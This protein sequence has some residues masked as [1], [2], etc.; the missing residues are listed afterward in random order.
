MTE[1]NDHISF[2]DGR[3]SELDRALGELMLDAQKVLD[4]QGRLRSLLHA[5]RSV[6][7]QLDLPVVLRR[8]VEAAVELV[9]ARYG[10]LGVVAPDGHLEQ[11]VHV[12]IP[13][14]LAAR[15]GQLP[16]GL[17]LLGALVEDPRPIRLEH[18]GADPRSVGFP[19]HHPPMDSFVGVPVRVRDEVFGNLYLSEAAAG[20][21]T[22]EDEELLTALAAT[23]GVA[24][25]NA[26]LFGE[27]RRRQHWSSALAEITTALLSDLD[28]DPLDMLAEHVVSLAD[29]DL[30]TVLRPVGG[31]LLMVDVAKG[32][33]AGEL[34]GL[35]FRSAGT[36]TGRAM[37][38]GQPVLVSE[39]SGAAERPLALGPTM[40]IPMVTSGEPSG[41]LSVAR[42]LGRPT[43]TAQDLEMA[44][45]F[46]RQ[47]NVAV[48][49]AAARADQQRFVILEDRSRIAG[50]LHDHVIQR[51]FAAGLGLQAVAGRITDAAARAKITEQVQSLDEAITAIRT[52]IFALTTQPSRKTPPLRH[53]VIDL[54]AE[55]SSIFP[56][57]PRLAFS[58]PVDLAIPDAV[59]DDLLAVLREGLTNVARHADAEEAF[60][61]ITVTDDEAL[62]EIV[63]NG[64]GIG[65][66]RRRSGIASMQTRAARWDGS[67]SYH[68]KPG[69]GTVLDWTARLRDAEDHGAKV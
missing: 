47:A 51:L 16:R 39:S 46:A 44:T 23:A 40:V 41:A 28:A 56:L 64:V 45:D 14:E 6:V 17:G 33:L 49:L 15:M 66:P 65:R 48:Q 24:I 32:K 19:P 68:A 67:V 35:V 22:E 31:D 12:G 2:P 38:S 42:M 9:G 25:D 57:S 36:L 11:F 69:G 34:N 21:F 43:F 55:L 50:D 30:V 1:R 54:V 5:S 37:A 20:A 7:E 8:I 52:A 58:G 62:L 27:T 59:A 18:L 60:V 10:A 4:T 61:S 3:R 26:R 29:A 53:R 13:D 63:D